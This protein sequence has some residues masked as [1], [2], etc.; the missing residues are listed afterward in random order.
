MLAPS[1]LQR[2][3]GILVPVL[4]FVLASMLMLLVYEQMYSTLGVYLRDVHAVLLQVLLDEARELP[5]QRREH[6]VELQTVFGFQP[7]TIGHYRQAVQLLT[8]LAMQT[9][10]GIV[11]AAASILQ[12]AE[13][14]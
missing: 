10:K 2:L 7:F 1:A 9:D 4:G 12:T 11:L 5:V 14:Q 13:R 6:L 8:E 3:L